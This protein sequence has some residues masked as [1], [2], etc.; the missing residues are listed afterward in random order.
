[1]EGLAASAADAVDAGEIRRGQPTLGPDKRE[2]TRR[3]WD[4]VAQS[5]LLEARAVSQHDGADSHAITTSILRLGHSEP[6]AILTEARQQLKACSRLLRRQAQ[7][8]EDTVRRCIAGLPKPD[9]QLAR[10]GGDEMTSFLSKCIPVPHSAVPTFEV[11]GPI[12]ADAARLVSWGCHRCPEQSQTKAA[13]VGACLDAHW[14]R[15]HTLVFHAQVPK[16][17]PLPQRSDP[18]LIAGVCVWAARK[19]RPCIVR[20]TRNCVY[21]RGS[22]SR[23]THLMSG[24]VFV[25][26]ESAAD[27]AEET[28]TTIWHVCL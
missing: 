5:R 11:R 16:I 8:T 20:S 24:S 9:L 22:D 27:E 23:Q 17:P 21:P 2:I 14:Q 6:R 1:M 18:C 15:Q 25:V 3:V 7:E 10:G 19:A 13:N 28:L 26:L 12:A 4:R